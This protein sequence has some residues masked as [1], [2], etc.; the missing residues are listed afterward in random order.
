MA[1]VDDIRPQ[2]HVF[3]DCG[4]VIGLVDG[5]EDGLIRLT[6]SD[7]DSRGDHHY[8]PVEWVDHVDSHV[9]L[10]RPWHEVEN[11]WVLEAV[12]AEA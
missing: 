2:M 4:T 9:H 5:L 1:N 6:G 11:D 8:I 7:L 10:N 12:A 3:T